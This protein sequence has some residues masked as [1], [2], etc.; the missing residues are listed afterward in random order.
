MQPFEIFKSGRHTAMDRTVLEFSE[1]DVAATAAAYNTSRHEAPIVV[2]HPA[3]NA[4]AYGWIESLTHKD[5]TLIATPAQVDPAFAEMVAAGRFKKVSASFY[6]PDAASNPHPGVWAL[7]HVGFLG[8]QPPAVKGLKAVEL[9]SDDD[10]CVTVAFGEVPGWSVAQ[11][12]RSLREWIIGEFGQDKA[13]RAL[14]GYLVDT[15]QEVAAQPE[16]P[17]TPAEVSAQYQENDRMT[18]DIAAREAAIKTEAERL[19]ADRAALAADQAAFAAARRRDEATAFITGLVAAGKV[20]PAEQ[21][22][23]AA[24]V[25]SLDDA[26]SVA[27]GEG[28][29]ETKTRRAFFQAWLTSLPKRVEFAEL[30]GAGDALPAGSDAEAIARAALAF[31]EQQR[32]AGTDVQ[33]DAAVR[34]VITEQ[35]A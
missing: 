35:T 3:L 12:L 22:G 31:M 6:R 29:G 8:A 25:A 18:T 19:A 15:V 13:D 26:E 28:E 23:L 30:A 2:G 9:G 21:A 20:L 34:H 32:T 10:G 27:F 1:D 4:P 16:T 17:P 14:P 11:L 7:R 24:F 5:G 33:L